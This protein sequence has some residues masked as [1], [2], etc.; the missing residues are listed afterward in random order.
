[1]EAL[2]LQSSISIAMRM[3]YFRARHFDNKTDNET[4][5]KHSLTAGL[6]RGPLD[7]NSELRE[8]C[9]SFMKDIRGTQAYWNSVKIQLFAMFRTLGLPT[10]FIT[11]SADDNN[12]VDLMIIL[13]KT[14]G[15]NLSEDE[16]TNLSS[17]EKETL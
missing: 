8:N 3:R 2:K 6:L 13:S 10:F 9:Y 5:D 12:W 1:M 7:D 14:G 11:L 15:Q 4:D 16:A 17:S